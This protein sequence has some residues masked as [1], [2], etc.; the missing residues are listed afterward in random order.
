MVHTDGEED[1]EDGDGGDY[2]VLDWGEKGEVGI[3]WAFTTP[4]YFWKY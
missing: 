1:D 3:G 2:V 4:S